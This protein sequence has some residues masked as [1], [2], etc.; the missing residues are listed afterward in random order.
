M[1]IERQVPVER[2]EALRRDHSVVT[3]CHFISDV[4]PYTK[5]KIRTPLRNVVIP[6]DNFQYFILTLAYFFIL[7]VLMNARQTGLRQMLS[8]RLSFVRY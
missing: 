4:D 8:Q 1:D 3:E 2:Y 5:K 6:W 7:D